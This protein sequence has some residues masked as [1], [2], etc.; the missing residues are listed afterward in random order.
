[1]ETAI[2]H[3]GYLAVM[4]G[5]FLEGETVLILGGFAAH[6]GYLE[7]PWVIASAFAG[8]VCGDQLF[9]HLGRRHSQKFLARRPAWQPRIAKAQALIHRHRIAII[10]GFR[11]IYGLRTA[12]PFSLGVA[13]VPG[14]IFVPLNIL[15]ALVWSV[16]IGTA[17]YV[18]GQTLE[19]VF[20]RLKHLEFWIMAA[21]L[22]VWAIRLQRSRHQGKR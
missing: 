19:I 2:E 22:A 9:Y 11:F 1:M 7:L 8:T 15:G 13:E 3:F 10:L 5:T 20:G 4:I 14:R 12:I 18:F 16:A 17:G 6:R 21:G